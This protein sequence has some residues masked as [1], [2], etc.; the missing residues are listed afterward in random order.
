MTL[1]SLFRKVLVFSIFGSVYRCMGARFGLGVSVR[2]LLNDTTT[3]NNE[4]LSTKVESKVVCFI[5]CNNDNNCSSISYDTTTNECKHFSGFIQ[6]TIEIPGI[7][8]TDKLYFNSKF[9]L[10]SRHIQNKDKT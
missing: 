1:S 3:A 4:I 7:E 6:E 2:V 8:Q 5:S 10:F 9:N